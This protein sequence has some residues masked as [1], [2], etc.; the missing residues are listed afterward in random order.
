MLQLLREFVAAYGK[1]PSCSEKYKQE[2][3]G[4]W[5]V[6]QKKYFKQGKLGMGR[7]Q[8]LEAVPGW[9]WDAGI[10]VGGNR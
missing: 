5:C 1:Q 7:Q 8:Q 10:P 6:K 9:M 3:L 2:K 4:R